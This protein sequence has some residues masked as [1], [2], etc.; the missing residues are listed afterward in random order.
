MHT[1]LEFI[2][3]TKQASYIV[4]VVLLLSFIPFWKLLIER[5]KQ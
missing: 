1:F 4:A 3:E 2:V 5:E